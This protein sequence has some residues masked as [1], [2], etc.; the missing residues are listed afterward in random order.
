MDKIYNVIN[1]IDEYTLVI[2]YGFDEGAE[3]EETVRIFEEGSPINDLEG[4]YLGNIEIIKD[5]IEIF[6]VFDKFSICKKIKTEIVNPYAA[7]MLNGKSKKVAKK[8]N[9]QESGEFSNLIYKNTTKISVGDK[10]KILE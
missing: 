3:V 1:I 8:L 6:R 10:V 5:E 9:V 2:D 7:L 4:N